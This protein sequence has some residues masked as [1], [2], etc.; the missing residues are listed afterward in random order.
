M[1][2]F[3]RVTALQ[4]TKSLCAKVSSLLLPQLLAQTIAIKA[5]TP[6][7]G[8]LSFCLHTQLWEKVPGHAM[9]AS[10]PAAYSPVP[11]FS[12]LEDRPYRRLHSAWDEDMSPWPGNGGLALGS[13][14]RREEEAMG[15]ASGIFFVEVERYAIASLRKKEDTVLSTVLIMRGRLTV[16]IVVAIVANMESFSLRVVRTRQ[17][18]QLCL[19]EISCFQIS[20]CLFPSLRVETHTV[21]IRVER[22][23][24]VTSCTS[25]LAPDE[26]SPSSYSNNNHNKRNFARLVVC[27][28]R[29]LLQGLLFSLLSCSAVGVSTNTGKRPLLTVNSTVG[30]CAS[31]TV[32]VHLHKAI[33]HVS[34]TARIVEWDHMRSVV[35]HNVGEVAS[36][37][38]DTSRF[39]FESPVTTR[40]P[41]TGSSDRNLFE[42]GR[43]DLPL[44]FPGLMCKA[45]VTSLRRSWDK[46][47]PSVHRRHIDVV[48][49]TFVEVFNTLPAFFA[50]VP[51]LAL[52][53][54]VSGGIV[55]SGWKRRPARA[56]WSTKS[57]FANS[58]QEPLLYV[59]VPSDL[60]LAR[61]RGYRVTLEQFAYPACIF[62]AVLSATTPTIHEEQYRRPHARDPVHVCPVQRRIVVC[63]S[64]L[65]KEALYASRRQ[66]GSYNKKVWSDRV[67]KGVHPSLSLLPPLT[68]RTR[69]FPRL[70][71]LHA[72]AEKSQP[73][74]DLQTIPQRNE[75]KD[76]QLSILVINRFTLIPLR[77][78]WEPRPLLLCEFFVKRTQP[79]CVDLAHLQNYF[80]LKTQ[81][82]SHFQTD[83]SPL[84]KLLNLSVTT[85]LA[86]LF[87]DSI[88]MR[89]FQR[90]ELSGRYSEALW[91]QST[92]ARPGHPEG[93]RRLSSCRSASSLNFGMP[94]L[95]A[96]ILPSK[97]QMILLS[98]ASLNEPLRARSK[99][100]D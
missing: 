63:T 2:T 24:T 14:W 67:L 88:A 93:L 34:A 84:A 28:P 48:L 51:L 87:R 86:D 25:S 78:L 46:R 47:R 29:G 53:G 17:L 18:I 66:S 50:E 90:P 10:T 22:E 38:P 65:S 58:A 97:I 60:T 62:T 99:K 37:L 64:L 52:L 19:I 21:H 42:K 80:A 11:S 3:R 54:D 39:I 75:H 96:K 40:G 100:E 81:A 4:L 69:G 73:D 7:G 92:L 13:F 76:I 70:S 44:V 82:D 43:K 83:D 12:L 71:Q 91:I 8:P 61:R 41:N 49:S 27:L 56:G 36:L 26:V 57:K 16:I 45:S 20:P 89:Y 5:S 30:G 59:K 94:S 95:S 1:P 68:K 31:D 9:D 77:P 74:P 23:S 98:W 6:K 85:I 15:W 72:L 32:N 33:Q 35:E 79:I 55:S